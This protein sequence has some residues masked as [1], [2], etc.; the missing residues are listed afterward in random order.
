MWVTSRGSR[1]SIG[2]AAPVSISQSIV[3]E[4]N[5]T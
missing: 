4:D 2:I 3:A 1:R 5:A